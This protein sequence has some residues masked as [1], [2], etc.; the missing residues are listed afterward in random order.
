MLQEITHYAALC[1]EVFGLNDL[2]VFQMFHLECHDIKHGLITIAQGLMDQ[3]IES[4]AEQHK[5]DNE[6]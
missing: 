5:R 2:V 1:K 3:L 4:L 6:R